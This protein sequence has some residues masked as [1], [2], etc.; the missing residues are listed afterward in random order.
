VGKGHDVQKRSDFLTIER[1]QRVVRT[2]T[3]IPSLLQAQ[4]LQTK[5]APQL[6]ELRAVIH[7]FDVRQLVFRHMKKRRDEI[8]QVVRVAGWV[9]SSWDEI[10]WDLRVR[11]RFA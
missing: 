1:P 8:G 3:V 5:L 11:I 4:H 6:L 9:V 10:K 2:V 7:V